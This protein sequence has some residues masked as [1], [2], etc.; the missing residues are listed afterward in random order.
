MK[1]GF[2]N[3]TFMDGSGIDSVIYDVASKLS[4]KHDVEINTFYCNKK[5]NLIINILSKTKNKSVFSAYNPVTAINTI[6]SVKKYD[7]VISHICPMNILAGIGSRIYHKKHIA[8][9]WGSPPTS[10][11]KSILEKLYLKY[12]HLTE[13]IVPKLATVS[14]VPNEFIKKWNNNKKAIIFP[15]HGVDFK[16][17]DLKKIKDNKR[18]EEIKKNYQMPK[19]AKI[20]F[21]LG[22][23]L[24]YKG[25]DTLI[26]ILGIVRKKYPETYLLIGGSLWDKKYV[27]YL[28]NIS[29]DHTIL[30]GLISN[31]DLP[32]YYAL[33]DV[34][35]SASK[36][37]GQLCSEALAMKKPYVAWDI[38]SHKYILKDGLTGYLIKPYDFNGFAE[39]ICSIL[40]NPEKYEK[41]EEKGYEWVKEN[42]DYDKIVDKFEKL[43]K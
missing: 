40:D 34:Y 22:R 24:P 38:T 17:F 20:I 32:Y 37:E 13:K 16:R 23:V 21:S 3:H 43:L 29:D 41:I 36:W 27:E 2:Y 33:C 28:K 5:T 26:K 18:L 39:I 35:A 7:L 42:M 6:K 31:E 8:Y 1:I 9:F 10:S 14:L 12:L 15:M 25:Y 30:C 19:N 11:T 4:K